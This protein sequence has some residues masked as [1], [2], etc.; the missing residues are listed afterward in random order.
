MW[1]GLFWLDRDKWRAL[2][3]AILNFRVPQNA[4]KLSSGYTTGGLHRVKNLVT[5]NYWVS[6]LRQSSGILYTI[7]LNV[8][9]NRSASVLRRWE[10]KSY[11]GKSQ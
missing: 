8:S 11:F 4:R 7:E 10:G 2:V 9:E 3:N 6:G 5:Q 1:T